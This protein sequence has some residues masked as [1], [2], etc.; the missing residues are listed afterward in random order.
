MAKRAVNP[1]SADPSSLRGLTKAAILLLALNRDCSAA[2]MR[3][4][5]PNTIEELSREI[6]QLDLIDAPERGRVI[7]EFYNLALA[8]QYVKQGGIKH[9][10]SILEKPSLPTR[11]CTSSESSSVRCISSPFRSWP[12]RTPRT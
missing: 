5:D 9:A 12:R 2:V 11:P 7:E 1:D 10:R 3:Q 6:A 8:R 4:L